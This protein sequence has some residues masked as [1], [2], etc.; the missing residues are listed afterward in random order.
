MS[1][2]AVSSPTCYRRGRRLAAIVTGTTTIRLA[3]ATGGEPPL[4]RSSQT[5]LEERS[6]I[7]VDLRQLRRRR[8]D[9]SGPARNRYGVSQHGRRSGLRAIG[10]QRAMVERNAS[11]LPDA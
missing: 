7:P 4:S 3:H 8:P 5:C 11:V 9:A 1:R 10:V 2:R 6:M